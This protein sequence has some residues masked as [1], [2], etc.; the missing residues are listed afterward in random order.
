M[1]QKQYR[2]ANA[3]V[4]SVMAVIF[5]WGILRKVQS[6]QQIFIRQRGA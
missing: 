4:F 2:A 1:T 6:F 3:R 5:P